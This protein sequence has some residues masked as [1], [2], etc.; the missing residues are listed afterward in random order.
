MALKELKTLM[1]APKP[2]PRA[3]PVQQKT[4]LT[5]EDDGEIA[6]GTIESK[7]N[8]MMDVA[9]DDNNGNE[10]FIESDD[11]SIE[12]RPRK[13]CVQKMAHRK[14][15]QDVRSINNKGGVNHNES[16]Q[17]SE[18]RITSDRDHTIVA[19]GDPKGKKV[20]DISAIKDDFA[21]MGK[22]KDW[23]EKLVASKLLRPQNLQAVSRVSSVTTSTA[24]LAISKVTSTSAHPGP[25]PTPTTNGQGNLQEPTTV[26]LDSDDSL[27]R[28]AAFTATKKPGGRSTT[29]ADITEVR[30]SLLSPP[31]PVRHLATKKRTKSLSLP[32]PSTQPS[33]ATARLDTTLISSLLTDIDSGDSS[34]SED[35]ILP[36]SP[37]AVKNNKCLTTS[38]VSSHRDGSGTNHWYQNDDLPD[39]CQDGNAWHHVFILSVAHWAGGDVEPWGPDNSDLRETMQEI[40]DH[41]YWSRIQHEISRS[42]TVMKVAKQR[43]MEWRG[44]FGVAACSILTAFF[45]QDA[46]FLDS[47]ARMDFSKAMLKQNRFIFRDNSG[48][49]PKNWMGMWRSP[50]ILQTSVSHLNFTFGCVEIPTLDTKNSSARAAF[51]LAVTALSRATR[52]MRAPFPRFAMYTRA[53][54]PA[55]A[56]PMAPAI[57]KHPSTVHQ[58]PYKRK[59]AKTDDGDVWMPVI[60]KGKQ[61][62]FSKPIWGGMTLKFMGP[63]SALSDNDFASIVEEAQQYAKNSKNVGNS[64]T[65][66]SVTPDKDDIFAD[67]FAFR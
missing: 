48:L 23:A 14:A 61:Y 29:S 19:R 64:R 52:A 51:A 22:T 32:P 18:L 3:R 7:D 33:R 41:I 2:W 55:L 17:D 65:T 27:E 50:F 34:P 43:L 62:S 12:V 47:V 63:I 6:E 38:G 13:K 66:T 4:K 5:I 1:D 16:S 46:D 36:S 58:A 11:E 10:D 59:G 37:A 54:V 21:G 30:D 42:G 49:I 31:P 45:A 24:V 67:L 53:R 25:P 44:G 26:F 39:G 60:A 9:T 20:A 40:W 15:I 28:E 8:E 56:R 35:I 57:Q